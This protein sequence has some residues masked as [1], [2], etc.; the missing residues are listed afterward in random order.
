[1]RREERWAAADSE[2]GR[3]QTGDAASEPERCVEMKTLAEGELISSGAGFT[4]D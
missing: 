4:P 3:L 2:L 1:M